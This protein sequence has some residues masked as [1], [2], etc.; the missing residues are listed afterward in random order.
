[1]NPLIQR[2]VEDIRSAVVEL[3]EI[4]RDARAR[5]DKIADER[6]AIRRDNWS[7]SKELATL[8]RRT[9]DF[10]AIEEE[11]QKFQGQRQELRER[12]SRVLDYTKALTDE[13]QR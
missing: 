10:A 9:R 5:T 4:L 7:Q 13:F 3:G 1:M 2:Q 6:D 12:L 8:R 11:N